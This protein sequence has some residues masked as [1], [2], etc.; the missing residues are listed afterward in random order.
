MKPHAVLR[1]AAACDVRH[2][3]LIESIIHN[4]L[5]RSP[6]G[7]TKIA[8]GI[9][10]RILDE[11]NFDGQ[12][13]IRAAR[14]SKHLARMNNGDW[15]AGFPISFARLPDGQ[16]LLVDGQNRLSAIVMRDVATPVRVLI[17]DVADEEGAR[18]LYAFFDERDSAR[19]MS[20]VLD[21][22]GLGRNM[23]VRKRVRDSVYGALL[24]VNN[25]FQMPR[26][27]TIALTSLDERL[28]QFGDWEPQISAWNDVYGRCST[29]YRTKLRLVGVTA[30]G[31]YTFRHQPQKAREFWY[32][33]ALNDGL[34]KKDPRATLINDF[35]TRRMNSGSA[36]QAMQAPAVAWNAFYEGREL[37]IIKC[38]D[39]V[40]IRI[41][42]TPL[43]HPGRSENGA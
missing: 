36:R 27:G 8:P 12:R 31:L 7:I 5:Q 28:C 14:V 39:S 24:L 17:H 32:G 13:P 6:D 10:R 3:N 15:N 30:V 21:G 9:A 1:D 25:G 41:A 35:G 37:A 33:V 43:A 4:A 11:T 22:I 2:G 19:S 29:A 18:H 38:I 42:G 40:D 16:L 20:E 34:R 23:A 26:S